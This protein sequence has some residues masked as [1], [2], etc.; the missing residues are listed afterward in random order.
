MAEIVWGEG[1]YSARLIIIGQN[2]GPEEMEQNRPFVGSSGRV[3]DRALQNV[4]IR[5]SDCFVTNA[6]KHYVPS[7]QP[8]PPLLLS[9]DR[10]LLDKELGM[11]HNAEVILTL[12]KEAFESL[13]WKDLQ[14][15]HNRKG[16]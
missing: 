15:R 3:L 14:I 2:P 10:P 6:C 11:L 1:P 16:A 5:R 12:G 13:T 9:A 8:V 7:G 4:G